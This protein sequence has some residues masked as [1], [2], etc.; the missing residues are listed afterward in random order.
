[1][2]KIIFTSILI[3]LATSL[4]QA[5]SFSGKG[6]Q[7]L[8]AGFN[9][10]GHGS[11]IKASYDYGLN[12]AFS[13]GAGAVFYNTG[14]YNSD[15]FIFGRGDYH[16]QEIINYLDELDVYIG[17]ELGLI[18]NNNFGIMG[19]IGGRYAFTDRLYVFIEIGNNGAIG[20]SLDL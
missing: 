18:G 1:M 16:F 14:T 7:K 5:Q 10:Y 12:D 20:I 13:I 6:D 2:K 11:G 8:Q 3:I 9:F 17:A 4:A 19:H 15:F